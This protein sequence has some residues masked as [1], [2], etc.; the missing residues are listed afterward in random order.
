MGFISS[1]DLFSWLS[2]ALQ[3]SKVKVVN[4]RFVSKYSYSEKLLATCILYNN[5]SG[6]HC[7]MMHKASYLCDCDILM[8]EI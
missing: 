3:V 8:D 5:L 4:D 1:W 2:G 6:A 7:Y